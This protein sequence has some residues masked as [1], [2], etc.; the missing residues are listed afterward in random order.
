MTY[1]AAGNVTNLWS[2]V[3]SIPKQPLVYDAAG[4]QAL[5]QSLNGSGDVQSTRREY[6]DGD[7]LPVRVASQGLLPPPPTPEGSLYLV[8]SSVLGGELIA[9]STGGSDSF[10]TV[11]FFLNGKKI[12]HQVQWANGFGETFRNVDWSYKE[13]VIGSYMSRSRRIGQ[14]TFGSPIELVN[15]VSDNISDP[16]GG[17]LNPFGGEPPEVTLAW[18][19][20]ELNSVG[21]FSG[22][23]HVMGIKTPCDVAMRTVNNGGAIV[24][25]IHPWFGLVP[26]VGPKGVIPVWS[27]DRWREIGAHE[28]TP[29]E[30]GLVFAFG[31]QGQR[32]Q[33]RIDHHPNRDHKSPI[34]VTCT[35]R[36][37]ARPV[38]GV[39][40]LPG[41][42]HAFVTLTSNGKEVAYHAGPAR[43]SI[44]NPGP[45][46]ASH[47]PHEPGNEPGKDNYEYKAEKR[48]SHVASEKD[49]VLGDCS[50][51]ARLFSDVEDKTNKAKLPY[52]FP[53]GR[54]DGHMNN[55]NAYAYTLLKALGGN[56]ADRL[57]SS[58]LDQVNKARF[59]YA[60]QP[61]EE[62]LWLAGWGYQLPIP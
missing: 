49:T 37:V 50:Q 56:Y 38:E 12:A 6:Y 51:F 10:R 19:G 61:H 20:S 2:N 45:L 58:V 7:G 18:P 5:H 35:I 33:D 31:P 30:K 44:F 16:T 55:S 46:S 32:E 57:G 4:Q 27:L 23:C 26:G 54:Y 52:Q 39:G 29:Y 15:F 24:E 25:S 47:E 21:D 8:R 36:L 48:A 11:H 34:P 59:F 40:G 28:E 14:L 9:N 3:S 62:T 1:D 22:G 53:Y 13:P 43:S 17:F 41:N 42:Y 60:P